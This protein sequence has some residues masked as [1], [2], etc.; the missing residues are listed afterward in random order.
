MYKFYTLLLFIN[1]KKNDHANLLINCLR[2]PLVDVARL[3]M[4]YLKIS[5]SQNV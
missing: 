3:S 1:Y 5:I 4:I 2:G